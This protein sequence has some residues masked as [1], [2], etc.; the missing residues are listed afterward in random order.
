MSYHG[1]K[2]FIQNNVDSFDD[3]R[4]S[5]IDAIYCVDMVDKMHGEVDKKEKKK[6]KKQRAFTFKKLAGGSMLLE[7]DEE[8]KKLKKALFP[9]E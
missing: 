5:A 6:I 8:R 3:D 4:P 1:T 9:F 2:M 7:D